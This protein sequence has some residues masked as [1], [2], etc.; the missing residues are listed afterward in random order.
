[1]RTNL[2]AGAL[3]PPAV[4]LPGI[5]GLRAVAALSVL[6]MHIAAGLLMVDPAPRSGLTSGLLDLG[7][8]GV[9]LFFVLSAFSLANSASLNRDGIAEYGIKR[10]FRIAPLYYVLLVFQQVWQGPSS[11]VENILDASFLFNLAPDLATGIVFGGWTVGVEML[12]YATLPILLVACRSLRSLG[13]LALGGFLVSWAAHRSISVTWG[14]NVPP[15]QNYAT[16]SFASNIGAF[17]VGLLAHGLYRQCAGNRQIARLALM[18]AAA[19]FVAVVS[20]PFLYQFAAPGRPAVLVLFLAYGLLCLSQ[21]IRPSWLT[22]NAVMQHIGERSFS[23]YLV[24]MPIIVWLGPIFVRIEAHL[25]GF[26]LWSYG[27]G[28]VLTMPLVLIVANLAYHLVEVPG[29][30]LGRRL[31]ARRQDRRAFEAAAS[32]RYVAAAGLER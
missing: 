28:V 19:L 24:Q 18:L 14:A 4:K 11:L 21:A 8:T 30:N 6:V 25:G 12:F 26:T 31:I 9:H 16:F 29:V 10:L 5:H 15:F 2:F 7:G 17:C 3:V 13:L 23:V 22:T 1:M 27:T 32:G 20:S